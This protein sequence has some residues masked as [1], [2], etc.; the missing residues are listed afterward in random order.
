MPDLNA[1]GP[2]QLNYGPINLNEPVDPERDPI[3]LDY[4]VLSLVL[5][6]ATRADLLDAYLN[7]K[8][9]GGWS[10]LQ[11]LGLPHGLLVESEY[12]FKL[13]E[14]QAA[15]KQLQ[16]VA[17]TLIDLN[18]YCSLSCP[19]DFIL[20]QIAWLNAHQTQPLPKAGFEPD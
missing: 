15:L 13:P 16:H 14:T 19:S 20:R 1:N 11:E 17:Q 4:R 18:D 5:F 8:N 7:G 9:K 12:L 6:F 3:N 10:L 2:L